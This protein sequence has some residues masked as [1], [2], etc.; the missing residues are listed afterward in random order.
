VV[1]PA[2]AAEDAE[3]GVFCRRWGIPLMGRWHVRLPRLIGH[4]NALDMILTGRPVAGEEALRMGLANGSCEGTGSHGG[5]QAGSELAA[6]PQAALRGDRPLL[7]RTM[8]TRARRGPGREYRRG[9]ATLETGEMFAGLE[10]Y[11]SGAWR[12]GG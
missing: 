10:R 8:A 9:M 1:R 11:A 2:G 5:E 7:L 6:L 12:E 4:S 3:F